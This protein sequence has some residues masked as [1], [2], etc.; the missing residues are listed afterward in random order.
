MLLAIC[1]ITLV[2]LLVVLAI[3]RQIW[4]TKNTQ[5]R[6][7][8]GVE[9]LKQLIELTKLTQQHRGMHAGFLNGREEFAQ[10]LTELESNIQ[11]S[12]DKLLEFETVHSSA[13]SLGVQ[14]IHQKW[15]RICNNSHQSSAES[16]RSHSG[17]IARMLDSLWDMADNF[18]LTSSEDQTIRQLSTQFVKTIPELTESLGQIRALSVQVASQHQIS[19]DK[20]LQLLYTLSRIEER[21]VG[22]DSHFPESSLTSLK[23]FLLTIKTGTENQGL[24]QQN[25]DHLFKDAT[26]VI[27]ELF[28]F[29]NGGFIRIQD[30]IQ[31][32]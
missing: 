14:Q 18:S 31:N 2:I 32:R 19:A 24:S 5:K 16:F 9:G 23:V 26:L 17:L 28:T 7:S 27:D 29:I 20:K 25:P 10:K 12:I 1:S 21:I 22:L 15:Q 4:V 13:Q 8:R 30:Q 6:A 3:I 11:L